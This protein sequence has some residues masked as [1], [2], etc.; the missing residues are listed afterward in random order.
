MIGALKYCVAQPNFA[1]MNIVRF[2][3]EMR[4]NI[5]GFKKV[6]LSQKL[7]SKHGIHD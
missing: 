4:I 5:N 7:V 3:G 6:E 1:C 2:I